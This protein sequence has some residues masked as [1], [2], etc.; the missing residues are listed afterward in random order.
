M[1]GSLHTEYCSQIKY[2]IQIDQQRQ[3]WTNDNQ[4]AIKL[5]QDNFRE[6]LCQH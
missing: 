2:L 3:V 4:H 1:F 5:S 6:P